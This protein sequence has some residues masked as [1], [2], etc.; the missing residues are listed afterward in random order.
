MKIE[1]TGRKRKRLKNGKKK[2]PKTKK[3]V[4]E[5]ERKITFKIRSKLLSKL[6]S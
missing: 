4:D 3:K 6:L 2:T 5:T 1:E